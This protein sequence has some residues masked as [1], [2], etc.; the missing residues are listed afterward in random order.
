MAAMLSRSALKVTASAAK[1]N[2]APRASRVVPKASSFN[3][4]AKM[5]KEDGANAVGYSAA[6]APAAAAPATPFDGY[7]FAPIRES[8]VRETERCF[9]FWG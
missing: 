4:P 7:K 1:D 6:A 5:F 2:K 9:D 3:Q 8:T